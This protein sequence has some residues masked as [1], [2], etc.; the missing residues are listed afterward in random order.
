MHRPMLLKVAEEGAEEYEPMPQG[1]SG[2]S[3]VTAIPFQVLEF[4][5][6][7]LNFLSLLA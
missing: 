4:P 2:E 5:F 1:V 6:S 3:S 7:T